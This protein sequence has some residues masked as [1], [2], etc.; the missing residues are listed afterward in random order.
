[1]GFGP[2]Y[3]TGGGGGA[4]DI[5]TK[6][7]GDPAIFAN[8]GARDTYFTTNPDELAKIKSS[9]EAAG[10]GT[11]DSITAAYIYKQNAWK[12]IATNFKGDPGK[13]GAPGSGIDYSHLTEGQ[14]PK[15]DSASQ[16]FT[17]SG[18]TSP[19]N[20]EIKMSPSSLIFG[21]HKM[22]SAVADT[23]FT[24]LDENEHYSF[25]YYTMNPG[26]KYA[27]TREVDSN[28]ESVVR[29]PVGTDD[30]TNPSNEVTI[31]TSEVFYGGTF[32]LSQDTQK[33][34]MEMYDKDSTTDPIWI[35]HLGDLPAGSNDIT[36]EVPFKC[37][38]GFK[39][40]IRL[41]SQVGDLVAKGTGTNFSWTARRAKMYIKTLATQEWTK[42][43]PLISDVT[44]SGAL[45][46]L[47]MLDGTS[48]TVT[49]P[50]G[51]GVL[52]T[53]AAAP[54]SFTHLTSDRIIPV[55][56]VTDST[57]IYKFNE[58]S[59]IGVTIPATDVLPNAKGHAIIV[60]NTG[61]GSL[62]VRA[63]GTDNIDSVGTKYLTVPSNQ[64][65]V[66]VSD[67]VRSTWH[68]LVLK[69]SSAQ[70]SL[71]EGQVVKGLETTSNGKDLLVKYYDD[72][73]TT[74]TFDPWVAD[75]TKLNEAIENLEKY[76]KN[77]TR[78]FVYKGSDVPTF[79]KRPRGGYYLTFFSLKSNLN[80][81]TPNTSSKIGDGT[82]LFIDNNSKDYYINVATNTGE[83]ID[84]KNTTVIPPETTAWYVRNDNDWQEMYSGYLPSS[85]QEL[86]N[87]IKTLVSA[88]ASFIRNLDVQSD[89]P[90]QTAVAATS[91]EFKGFDVSSPAGDATKGIIQFKGATFENPDGSTVTT[92]TLK[93]VGMEVVD[94]GDGTPPKLMIV[95]GAL[96]NPHPTSAYGFFSAAP[97]VSD[98]VDFTTLTKFTGGKVTLTKSTADP[99]YA[100]IL[101][102]SAEGAG[103]DRIGEQGGLPAF[104]DKTSKTYTV[105][106]QNE[107][108]TVFRSPY[109]LREQDVTLII[110]H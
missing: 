11:V 65:M 47:A 75:I 95:G 48:K 63:S 106:G 71:D 29:V 57:P 31:A 62:T 79:Q 30:V 50:G 83:T 102:P 109:Q 105:N 25:A 77:K 12:P 69:D 78:F 26:D 60:A 67:Y 72:T 49:L 35:S 1:M 81:T 28:V 23:T 96:P 37:K 20:G 93:L 33:V 51:G 22:S 14:I 89:D 64:I 27:Y 6:K 66:L 98:S 45:L 38:A 110:Y 80:M 39:Y 74:L 18:I 8:T 52:P 40:T 85:H 41:L 91:L 13:A 7:N 99:Q 21:H 84:G 15:W 55:S 88:D 76:T 16:R 24:D 53:S 42:A 101:I 9:G 103:A 2:A 5:F 46:N 59:S 43:L 94:P 92:N 56:E 87:E 54:Y 44:I 58:A 107:A 100:Y 90:A 17:N 108:F 104:W 61:T 73:S 36:F 86:I 68:T 82:I 4:V 10:I 19:E 34:V 97:T 70:S 32:I 3:G